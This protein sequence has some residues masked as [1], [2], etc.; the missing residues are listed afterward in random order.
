MVADEVRVL[1]VPEELRACLAVGIRTADLERR[2]DLEQ[3]AMDLA[4]ETLPCLGRR[5]VRIP[6]TDPA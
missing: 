3:A 1:E 2:L 6:G 4:A 5:P